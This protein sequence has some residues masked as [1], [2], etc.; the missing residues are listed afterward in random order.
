MCA[1][2]RRA[3]FLATSSSLSSVEEVFLCL[4]TA[5]FRSLGRSS[6]SGE[7]CCFLRRSAASIMG[8]SVGDRR[9]GRGLTGL[10]LFSS[11]WFSDFL[12]R[13]GVSS[14]LL[15][16]CFDGESSSYPNRSGDS[17]GGTT[18]LTG[19][20]CLIGVDLPPSLAWVPFDESPRGRTAGDALL[21]EVELFLRELLPFS[22]GE[23]LWLAPWRD[24]SL[25]RTGSSRSRSR[26]RC[27]VRSSFGRA[28]SGRL[29]FCGRASSSWSATRFF[30]LGEGGRGGKAY[31]TGGL[32]GKLENK[33]AN[34]TQI[35]AAQVVGASHTSCLPRSPW[36]ATFHLRVPWGALFAHRWVAHQAIVWNR[37]W[38]GHQTK[39]A[40]QNLPGT[41]MRM[42]QRVLILGV[43][44]WLVRAAK[45]TR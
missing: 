32:G 18:G 5:S 12:D 17:N 40:P 26:S 33:L 24:E 25:F 6:G 28:P 3:G 23:S 42:R 19:L 1:I 37:N 36:S 22:S 4:E 14:D 43:W 31:L 10:R 29:L 38:H 7:P 30:V 16:S 39:D 44:R 35:D 45:L 20:S 15:L 34:A 21:A 41:T 9:G 8:G 11:A 27:D 13:G 2:M